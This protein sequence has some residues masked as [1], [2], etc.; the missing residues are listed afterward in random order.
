MFTAI[1][2]PKL[3]SYL[4]RYK[5]QGAILSALG[6]DENGGIA[7]VGSKGWGDKALLD[8]ADTIFR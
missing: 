1:P 8:L 5:S 3:L 7:F 2:L 4:K 6:A